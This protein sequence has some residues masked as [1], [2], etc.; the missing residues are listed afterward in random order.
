M[1]WNLSK[2]RLVAFSVSML[3]INYTH[4]CL[5]LTLPFCVTSTLA[6]ADNAV[7][8]VDAGKGLEPQTRKL[9]EVGAHFFI[10]LNNRNS[11]DLTW[12]RMRCK[13]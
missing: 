4:I 1:S 9:F 7:M 12:E 10:G 6:A 2:G 5:N 8:L 11:G 3:M 13:I